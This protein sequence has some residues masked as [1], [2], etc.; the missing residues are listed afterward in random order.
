MYDTPTNAGIEFL[1]VGVP[2][3]NPIP[4]PLSRSEAATVN[5]LIIPSASVDTI[6]AQMDSFVADEN[7]LQ[8]F[9]LGQFADYMGLFKSAYALRRFL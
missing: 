8:V 1:R 5:Q 6:L 9:C 2:I 7:S 3:L 4:A